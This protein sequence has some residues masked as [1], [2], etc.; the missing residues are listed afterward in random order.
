MGQLK[1]KYLL[2]DNDGTLADTFLAIITSF[3]HAMKTH[4]GK[5]S[6]EQKDFYASMM[7]L[8][9]ED[10]FAKFTDDPK[11]Q[12]DLCQT[13]RDINTQQLDKYLTGFDGMKETLAYLQNYGYKMGVVTSKLHALTVKGLKQLEISNYFD[14]I[15]GADDWHEHKPDPGAISHAVEMLGLEPHEVAYIGDAPFDICAGNGAGVDTIAVT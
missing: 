11:L 15:Q 10:Q 7:G 9:L 1:Y 2:F 13:Y 4:F 8:P 3:E 5:V 6:Q 14:Y 12:K